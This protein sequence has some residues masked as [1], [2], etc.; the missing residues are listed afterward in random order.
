MKPFRRGIFC[1]LLV[2]CLFLLSGCHFAILNPKG[3]IAATEKNVLVD[4]VLLMLI[5]VIPVIILSFLVPWRYRESNTKA[6]YKPEWSHSTIL[7]AIWWAI[8]CVI[9]LIL[10]ILA[11]IYTHSLDPYR[12]LAADDDTVMIE[13]IALDWKWLFIYPA[14]H[15]A[16]VNLLELPVHKPIRLF[17]TADAPMNSLEIPQLAG[18]IYAMTGMQTKLNLRADSTGDFVGLSTNYSGDGFSGMHFL[19][20]V[21][22]QSQYNA[23]IQSVAQSPKQLDMITYNQLFKPSQ[24]NPAEYFS[25]VTPGLFST[26][27]V[28]YMGPMPGMALGYQSVLKAKAERLKG[29]S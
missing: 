14:Q 17:I 28:K 8:P 9:I 4:A 7:E 10:A 24:N 29:N 3:I 16:T 19:V 2:G 26:T 11:W 13:A 21:V 22:T 15:I 5:V 20:K 25:N 18:Q 6:V 1:F 27:I 23:W 12:P